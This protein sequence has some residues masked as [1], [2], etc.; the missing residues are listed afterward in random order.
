[1]VRAASVDTGRI[2]LIGG[3]AGTGKTRLAAEL[4]RRLH[5]AGAAVLY[6]TCDDDL[7]LP[8]QPWVQALD[9]VVPILVAADRQLAARLTPLVAL[10][11][12][13][14]RFVSLASGRA[15]AD[16][17]AERYRRYGA[18][19]QVLEAATSTWP[20]LLV[21]DDL[22][23]AGAQTLALLRHLPRLGL[24][25]QL[26]IVATFR[27]TGDEIAEPLASLLADLRRV[28]GTRRIGLGGLDTDSVVRFVTAA[29]GGSLDAD[30]RKV[31]HVL[32]ERTDGNPFYVGGAAGSTSSL[33]VRSSPTTAGSRS[34]RS[35][36]PGTCPTASARSSRRGSG[37]CRRSHRRLL[38]LAAIAGMQVELAVLEL[39]AGT[40]GMTAADVSA[41]TE[42]LVAAGLLTFVQG[43]RPAYRFSHA[44]VRDT[45]AMA[46]APSRRPS[47]HLA[48][49]RGLESV[50]EPDPRP[51]LADLARHFGAAV[52]VGP[53]DRA[54]QYGRR[55]AGQAFR[56]AAYDEAVAHLMAVLELPLE[57]TDR[58]EL[59]VDLGLAH[60]RD[61]FYEPSLR[62]Y[63]EAFELAEQAGAVDAAAAAA[64]GFELATH[65]PGL[66]GGPAVELIGR[67]IELAVDSPM[68][69]RTRLKASF[70]RALAIAGRT[71]E[72]VAMAEETII[73]ARTIG[74]PE[75]L[76]V[77]LQALQTAL[78]DPSRRL[79]VSD[80]LADLSAAT[81]D[82]WG[83]CYASAN[84]VRALVQLGRFDEGKEALERHR[85]L[86]APGR[87][88]TYEFMTTA[89][90]AIFEMA[91][92]RFAEAEAAAARGQEL[93]EAS[94][95][96][97]GE[98]VYGLQMF[99]L[100]RAEGR[101]HEVA[102]VVQLLARSADDASVWRPGLAV[103]YV[104]LGM[105]DEARGRLRAVAA[106]PFRRGA[107]GCDLAG[108]P[109]VPR[110][111]GTGGR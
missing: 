12:S 107:A 68:V 5:A 14:E 94:N 95:S 37:D 81:G 53:T 88:A 36:R 54:V 9:P 91:A 86:S 70:A 27:D 17:E 109:D 77:A 19:A 46:V 23:W 2:V 104:E 102:P 99:A 24:P 35:L 71:E 63:G 6:G 59:L 42:E 51:I 80:E 83:A 13:A 78:D 62:T 92:G 60:L 72:G 64:V 74:D 4:A 106:R 96:P 67:A 8:Y 75:S 40:A 16:A 97:F 32:A 10:L 90:D 11:R 57:P 85:R 89:F 26:L 87:F 79:A 25:R 100:R 55:A 39:A 82:V 93:A 108:L 43:A 52:P 105:V 56:A 41:G 31:A 50:H 61:G 30:L 66:P 111:G 38:D 33:V 58:A 20:T 22:H 7:A 76:T 65:F 69:V 84:Q 45:V 98:G 21:L 101:L 49:A 18:F 3:E 44:I 47:L 48:I 29:A 73:D 34:A 28:D 1:M 15:G 110:R 103:L